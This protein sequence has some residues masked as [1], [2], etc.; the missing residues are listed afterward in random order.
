[1]TQAATQ[2]PRSALDRLASLTIGVAATALAVL[3]AVQGWQVFA[4]YVLDHSPG[5]IEPATAVLLTGAMSFGAAAGVHHERH[6]AFTL[7]ADAAPP[8]LRRALFLAT[9]GLIALL[10]AGLAWWATR[11]FLDGVDVR[12]AGAP[13][14]ESLPYAPVGLGGALMV[15]FAIGRCLPLRTRQDAPVSAEAR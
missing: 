9:K 8:G 7:L 6:F 14:P 15:V 5:W 12:A 13:F 3:V 11:L 2:A 10:G 1:M 4:R